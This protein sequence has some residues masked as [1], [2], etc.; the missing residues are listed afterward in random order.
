MI[1][2]MK[3]NAAQEDIQKV[4]NRISEAGLSAN[5]STGESLTIIGVIGD[6]TLLRPD[7]IEEISGVN[8]VMRVSRPYKL[9]SR[10]FNPVDRQIKIG[11]IT[12]GTGNFVMISGPCAVES[13]EQMLSSARIVKRV[14]ADLLRGGAF[15]PRTS[16]YDFQGLGEEGLKYLKEASEE[17][18]LP[19]VTEVT[20]EDKID[21]VL[22][23][24]DVLQIGTRN[25]RSYDLLKKI[26]ERTK[27][28]KI[29]VLL[30]R[31]DNATITEFLNAAEYI[32]KEGNENIM[33]CLRG[34][35]TF[36]CGKFVRNT[37]DMGII[38]VLK[39]ETG[40]PVIFD[41]SHSSGDRDLVLSYSAA[42]V[43]AGADGLIIETHCDPE[44]ASC[45]GKQSLA[46]N[47]LVQT[48]KL[49]R[50]IRECLV[51]EKAYSW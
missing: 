24:A 4:L 49:C 9:V 14:G 25:M 2:K 17:T 21:I 18:G 39:R 16:P 38:P 7:L 20:G 28:S 6:V 48:F 23:Y 22:K 11:S 40:L 32:A 31:G 30:K 47:Q 13:R 41:P 50:R 5:V 46:E 36:E 45:D 43:A 3:K 35:R 29:P 44:T 34:I 12:I 1:I 10:E 33:L 51:Q 42:A 8:A 37:A 27:D 19:I 15:K 26:G